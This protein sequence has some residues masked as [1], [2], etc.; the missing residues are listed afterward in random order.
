VMA[1]AAMK[2]RLVRKTMSKPRD[3]REWGTVSRMVLLR[4]VSVLTI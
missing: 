4:A 2:A 3:R 1:P